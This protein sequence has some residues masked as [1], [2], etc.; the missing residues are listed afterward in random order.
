MEECDKAALYQPEPCRLNM[1]STGGREDIDRHH[2]SPDYTGT[3]R[4]CVR[5]RGELND[6]C[7]RAAL[8]GLIS[9]LSSEETCRASPTLDIKWQ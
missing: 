2:N 5:S 1:Y 6:R 4:E 9:C 3:W 8:H 7:L